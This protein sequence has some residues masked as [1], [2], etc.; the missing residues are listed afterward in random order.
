MSQRVDFLGGVKVNGPNLV[1][2]VPQQVAALHAVRDPREYGSH[3]VPAII[4]ISPLKTS[5]VSNQPRPFCPI[6]T[7]GL[8]VVD[9]RA[10]SV[11]TD[12]VFLRSPVTPPIR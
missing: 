7:C 2:H 1:D 4:P 11:A 10:E 5:Q 6:R 9:K 8:I 12:A 3:H